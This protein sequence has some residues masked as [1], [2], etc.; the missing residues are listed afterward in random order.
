MSR[1]RLDAVLNT[2]SCVVCQR[3][4]FEAE[5]IQV[6]HAHSENARV[7]SALSTRKNNGSTSDGQI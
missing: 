5:V 7:G 6:R 4:E 1:I 3:A 2:V